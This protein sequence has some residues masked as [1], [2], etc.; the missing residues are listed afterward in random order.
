MEKSQMYYFNGIGMAGRPRFKFVK[1]DSPGKQFYMVAAASIPLQVGIFIDNFAI[2]LSSQFDIS[3]GNMTTRDVMINIPSR[4]YQPKN[5]TQQETKYDPYLKFDSYDLRNEFL[6]DIK[7][8][9]VSFWNNN[10]G[11]YF[12]LINNDNGQQNT[13]QPVAPPQTAA[14]QQQPVAPPQQ[15]TPPQT[16][17]AFDNY[18][19]MDNIEDDL[20]F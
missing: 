12:T 15:Q 1:V 8:H 13:N 6:E 3:N 9:F 19:P 4:S 2:S 5:T 18:N 20:P 17:S 10:K 7:N 14:P 11:D 16:G